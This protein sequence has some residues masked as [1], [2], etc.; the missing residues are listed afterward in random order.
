[1]QAV[2]LRRRRRGVIRDLKQPGQRAKWTPTGSL[3]TKPATSAHVTDVVHM[4][5]RASNV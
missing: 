2:F 5:F 1:M 3:L 4:A